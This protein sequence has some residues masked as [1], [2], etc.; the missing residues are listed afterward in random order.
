MKI[1]IKFC[2]PYCDINLMGF[3][4]GFFSID[5]NLQRKINTCSLKKI[6][7]YEKYRDPI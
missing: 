2:T 3:D 7:I 6:I 1:S 5:E 4:N